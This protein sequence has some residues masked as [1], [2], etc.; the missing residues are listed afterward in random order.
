MLRFKKVRLLQAVL[1]FICAFQVYG[2]YVLHRFLV[3]LG[4]D[5]EAY[6]AFFLSSA[7]DYLS[8]IA[9]CVIGLII[10]FAVTEWFEVRGVQ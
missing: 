6:L 9:L 1:I 3:M 4:Y 8:I 10:S 5:T 2:I 7:K